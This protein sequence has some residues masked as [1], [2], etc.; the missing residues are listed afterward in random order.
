MQKRTKNNLWIILCVGR[1]K[2]YR[3]IIF[4]DKWQKL[5]ERS[6]GDLSFSKKYFA[7][8][9][10]PRCPRYISENRCKLRQAPR[11]LKRRIA[12]APSWFRDNCCLLRECICAR[13]KFRRGHRDLRATAKCPKKIILL[14]DNNR[15]DTT[16]DREERGG[17]TFRSYLFPVMSLCE[18]NAAAENSS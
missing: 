13:S 7:V 1:G 15:N 16:N 6:L 10:S 14:I 3:R 5:Y 17:R 9:S 12:Q 8:V 2:K 18:I 4:S 11:K